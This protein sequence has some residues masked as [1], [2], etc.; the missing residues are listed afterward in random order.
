MTEAATLSYKDHFAWGLRINP[1]FEQL[2]HGIK[3]KPPRIPV[4]DRSAKWFALSNYR[5]FMLDQS[6]RYHDLEHLKLDYDQSGAELPQRAAMVQASGDDPEWEKPA[7]FTHNL[8]QAEAIRVAKQAMQAEKER[9]AAALRTKKLEEAHGLTTGHWFI[10]A[11]H[12]E[13]QEVGMEHDSPKEKGELEHVP[14]PAPV[15]LPNAM[16][17]LGALRPFPSQEQ[18]N[19]RQKKKYSEMRPLNLGQTSETSYENMRNEATGVA[20]GR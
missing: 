10:D 18:L 5:A 7:L 3:T 11:Q 17:Q 12:D 2:D 6:M 8:G 14:L 1:D 13:L 16:G 9:Q 19:Y 20:P 15:I 4:P